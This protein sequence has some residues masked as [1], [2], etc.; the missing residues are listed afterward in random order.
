MTESLISLIISGLIGIAMFFM[1]QANESLKDRV[2]TVED[3]L[4]SVEKTTVLKEDFR[5]FKEELWNRFDKM[6]IAFDKK[7]D[8][9]KK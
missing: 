7:L 2:K 1:K 8:E 4:Q 5:E 3:R 6:E 9:I